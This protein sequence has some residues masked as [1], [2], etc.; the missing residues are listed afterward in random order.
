MNKIL[1][2]TGWLLAV[3]CCAAKDTFSSAE[4]TKEE[5]V[6]LYEVP[7]DRRPP[8]KFESV[9][10]RPHFARCIVEEQPSGASTWNRL[11]AIDSSPAAERITTILLLESPDVITLDKKT[12]LIPVSVRI[13]RTRSD[14][15][16]WTQSR[17]LLGTA[18]GN[19]HECRHGSDNPAELL[20]FKFSERQVRFRLETSETPFTD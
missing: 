5:I 15:S 11:E 17:V 3:S 10:D 14:E 9:F 8:L 7:I 12:R 6:S 18:I 16:S 19:S 2:S 20:L 1:L 4:L 13:T